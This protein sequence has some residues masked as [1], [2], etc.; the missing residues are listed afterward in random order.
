MNQGL[1]KGISFVV[2]LFHRTAKVWLIRLAFLLF[3]VGCS[4]GND[5]IYPPAPAA[6]KAI[7]YDNA[8]FLINGQRTVIMS[9]SIHYQRIPHELRP[10]LC[11]LES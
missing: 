10:N 9:G 6:R 7:D 3:G 5:A 2:N 8:G 11:L 1:G 4:Y